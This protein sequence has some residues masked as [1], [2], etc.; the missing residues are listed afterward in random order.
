MNWSQQTHRVTARRSAFSALS[1]WLHVLLVPFLNG[2]VDAFSSKIVAS[3]VASS[4]TFRLDKPPQTPI[5]VALFSTEQNSNSIED[6]GDTTR[7]DPISSITTLD[8]LLP[9][10]QISSLVQSKSNLQGAM[11]VVFH[12]GLL[13]LAASI[14]HSI[15]QPVA[16]ALVSAF[17]FCGLHETVHRTA[18]A[19]RFLN[20]TMAQIFGLLTL[21]PARH[22]WYYHWQHHRY[23]GDPELD[24]ELQPGSLLDMDITNPWRYGLYLSGIPFWVDATS[25]LVRHALG[26]TPEMYLPTRQSKRQVIVEARLYLLCYA[27]MGALSYWRFPRLGAALARYWILP[28]LL[29]Q[30]IL[31]AYLLGEHHGLPTSKKALVYETTRTMSST[32]AFVKRLAWN[33]PYHLEHHAW[34][35]I[36]FW[37]LRETHQLFVEAVSSTE[38]GPEGGNSAL[39]QNL[40][41]QGGYARFNWNYLVS[42]F[43]KKGGVRWR[44]LHPE[45]FC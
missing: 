4:A 33:M 39:Y 18:F 44:N 22:Y 24:S 28:S 37:K 25:T 2:S 34:P 41:H 3:R 19:S 32:H 30:P 5:F 13:A 29:G 17:F 42:L 12:F 36:P 27:A 14:P 7:A 40:N 38:T 16:M 6:H 35:A 45:H 23:T 1:L 9:R 31:R 21:R 15:L 10:S 26:K 11:Q 20:D 43:H 8:S